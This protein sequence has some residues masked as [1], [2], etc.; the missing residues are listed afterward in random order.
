MN[1]E[2]DRMYQLQR[3]KSLKLKLRPIPNYDIQR[4]S[5][6]NKLKLLSFIII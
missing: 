5:I 3:I 2:K 1:E 4:V 6:S